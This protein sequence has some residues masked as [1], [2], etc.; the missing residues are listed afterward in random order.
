MIIIIINCN[1]QYQQYSLQKRKNISILVTESSSCVN[2]VGW[3]QYF[4]YDIFYLVKYFVLR[5]ISLLIN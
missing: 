4:V 3:V 5:M 1:A 2:C